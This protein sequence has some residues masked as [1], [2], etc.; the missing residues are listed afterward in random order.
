V[1]LDRD[2]PSPNPSSGER[3]APCGRKRMGDLSAVVLPLAAKPC[4]QGRT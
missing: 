2:G 1:I 4:A 3:R